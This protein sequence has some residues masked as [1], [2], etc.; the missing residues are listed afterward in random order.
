MKSMTTFTDFDGKSNATSAFGGSMFSMRQGGAVNF[1]GG[2][3]ENMVTHIMRKNNKSPD[4]DG[5]S[6]MNPSLRKLNG[7]SGSKGGSILKS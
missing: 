5:L 4:R 3:I 2:I 1:K 7:R 6:M